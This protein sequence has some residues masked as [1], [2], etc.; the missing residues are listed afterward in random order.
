[1]GDLDDDDNDDDEVGGWPL[2]CDDHTDDE[3]VDLD[4]DADDNDND[5]VA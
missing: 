2:W 4:D 3:G 5:G 1:M